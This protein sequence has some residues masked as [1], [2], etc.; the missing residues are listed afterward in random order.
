MANAERAKDEPRRAL[1]RSDE[2]HVTAIAEAL[3][4]RASG[5]PPTARLA[6]L[7]TDLQDHLGRCG[8]WARFTFRLSLWILVWLAPLVGSHLTALPK[9]P[10]GERVAVLIRVEKSLLAPAFFCVKVFLSLLYFEHPDAARELGVDHQPWRV[11][12]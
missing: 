7:V 3:F 4:S 6:W 9:L 11:R 10:L 5:P 1:S 8:A 12:S 2:A